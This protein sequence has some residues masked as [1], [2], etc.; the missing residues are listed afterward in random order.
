MASSLHVGRPLLDGTAAPAVADGMPR[1]A[2]LCGIRLASAERH[3]RSRRQFGRQIDVGPGPGAGFRE[4]DAMQSRN[5]G[6]RLT[7]GMQVYDA[8]GEKVGTIVAVGSTAIVV[9][10]GFF[11]PTDYSI[12]T[13]M[14]A[15]IDD[16]TAWLGVAKDEALARSWDAELEADAPLVDD[17]LGAPAPQSC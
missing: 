15:R 13:S 12:P 6:D 11:F 3:D 10:R 14:I 2:R 17:A 7:E 5:A 16:D 4:E 8:A 9:E 1:V